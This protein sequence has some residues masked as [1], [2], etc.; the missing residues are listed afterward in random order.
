[1]TKILHCLCY[2]AECWKLVEAGFHK[3]KGSGM[4]ID[5][6]FFINLIMDR[7]SLACALRK[8]D[9]PKK[10]LW[11]GAGVGA[12]G[13]CLWEVTGLPMMMRPLGALFLAGCMVYACIGKRSW[14]QWSRAM[15][16]VYGCSFLFA[17]VIPY[18]SQFIPIWISAVLI[19]YGGIKVWLWRKEKRK[20]EVVKVVFEVENGKRQLIAVV[21]TGHRLVEPIT[22]KPVVIIR[23][24]CLPET[25]DS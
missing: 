6:Y 14:T 4:Y 21:D 15:I 3:G 11:L 18:I 23:R 1:M 2:D 20:I 7:V 12:A 5:I 16:E 25:V 8:Y 9:L 19:S 22:G 24:D 17:G 10:K 13:A